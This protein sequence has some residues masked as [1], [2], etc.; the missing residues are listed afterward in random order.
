[1]GK[2]LNVSEPQFVDAY[3]ELSAMYMEEDDREKLEVS[4]VFRRF[5]NRFCR[6]N[7]SFLI[8]LEK[9]YLHLPTE[10]KG[11]ERGFLNVKMKFRDV[12]LILFLLKFDL[13]L[14]HDS[15]INKFRLIKISGVSISLEPL[16]E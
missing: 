12:R 16:I 9:E 3:A 8:N 4:L 1:M 2:D 7:F 13:I 14:L 6:C 15:H 11:I 5:L 10:R